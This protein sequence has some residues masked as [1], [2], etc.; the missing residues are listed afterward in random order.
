MWKYFQ[1]QIVEPERYG[2]ICAG[3]F[4]ICRDG[5]CSGCKILIDLIENFSLYYI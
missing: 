2:H 4:G 3:I 1:V 5:S